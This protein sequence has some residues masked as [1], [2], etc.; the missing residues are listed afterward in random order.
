M[1]Q[2]VVIIVDGSGGA[3]GN[4]HLSITQTGD[5]CTANPK[6]PLELSDKQR[7]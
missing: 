1:G 2:T 4:Y 5:C 3:A 6:F 7:E